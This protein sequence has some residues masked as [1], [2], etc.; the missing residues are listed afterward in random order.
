MQKLNLAKTQCRKSSAPQ[1]TPTAPT[2]SPFR[3]GARRGR[4]RRRSSRH[5][6]QGAQ[7]HL[8]RSFKVQ[9]I[10]NIRVYCTSTRFIIVARYKICPKRNK[11]YYSRKIL[12]Y[13]RK[14]QNMSKT[15]LHHILMVSNRQNVSQTRFTKSNS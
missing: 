8:A 2:P 14:I 4:F 5:H 13:S 6:S 15:Y 9:F 3:T 1:R 12:Y 7:H 11:V 10:D